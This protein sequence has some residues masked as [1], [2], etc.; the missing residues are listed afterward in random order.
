M[1]SAVATSHRY[2]PARDS[3][4]IL[5]INPAPPSRRYLTLMKGYLPSKVPMILPTIDP[6]VSV[7]YQITSPSFFVFSREE[8]CCA[9]AMLERISTAMSAAIDDKDLLIRMA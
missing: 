1:Y 2:F 9:V 4:L 5:S 7:P 3:L 6:P 8:V